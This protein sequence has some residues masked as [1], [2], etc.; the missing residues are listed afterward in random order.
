M[1]NFLFNF[2]LLPLFFCLS[3]SSSLEDCVHYDVSINHSDIVPGE[4]VVIEFNISID[5]GFH[6]YSQILIKA[7]AQHI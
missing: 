4:S 6:I 7:L 3:F 5:D 2:F 1:I